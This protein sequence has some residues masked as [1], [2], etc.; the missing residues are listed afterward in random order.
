MK[1]SLDVSLTTDEARAAWAV[2]K[3][4]EL[5]IRKAQLE[6]GASPI[7]RTGLSDSIDGF[8]KA[9]ENELRKTTTD[10]YKSA[11]KLFLEW[12]RARGIDNTSDL[13]ATKL[14]GFRDYLLSQRKRSY[15]RTASGRKAGRAE[16]KEKVSPQTIN[17]KLR[18]VKRVLNH[19]RVRGKVALSSDQIRDGLKPVKAPR[20]APEFL[21]PSE[22][23]KLLEAALR[24]DADTVLTRD[25]E[26][27]LRL[28]AQSQGVSRRALVAVQPKGTTPRYDPIAPFLATV[29]LTGM[30]AGEALALRWSSVDLTALDAEGHP[31]GEIRLKAEETKTKMA[32]TIGLDVS[33]SLRTL[34]TAMSLRAEGDE[35][36]FG[37][38]KPMDRV[39]VEAARRRLTGEVPESAR[40]PNPQRKRKVV[41]VNFGAPP[42]SWQ[43]L[44]STAATIG[45]NAA[46]IFGAAAAF[47]S[48]KRLGHS[49]TV[50][51]LHYANQF[52]V[53]KNAKTL[54][55]A[56]G[57]EKQMA[58]VAA[59]VGGVQPA[60]TA[61]EG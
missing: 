34:L 39:R 52:A 9:A 47:A 12:A 37:G 49:P 58:E 57:I 16:G 25:E 17:W 1:V 29:L 4:K 5:L 51:E 32:R 35:Y 54:E 14:P 61:K 45:S 33:P 3:S 60:R 50:G 2:R 42:F 10:L 53:S 28:E 43:L 23:Q 44:R 27:R 48:A 36:V 11:T 13:K 56:M 41:E 40:T 46:G 38:K 19:L 20:E 18:A 22:L 31:V 24:H 8:Y 7:E 21:R 15:Q 55:Q 26:K 59:R 30:R 6:G